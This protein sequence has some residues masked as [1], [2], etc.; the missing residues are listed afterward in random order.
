[1]ERFAARDAERFPFLA[2][3]KLRDAAGVRPGQPGYNPRT[4]WLPPNWF[5]AQKVNPA[6]VSPDDAH[7]RHTYWLQPLP[8][9]ESGSS[10][11]PAV[12]CCRFHRVSSSGGSSRYVALS[13]SLRLA[14]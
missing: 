5:K 13:L 6:V 1:M 8:D 14:S 11:T 4:L 7:T 10:T 2:A 12:R 9:V 3:G